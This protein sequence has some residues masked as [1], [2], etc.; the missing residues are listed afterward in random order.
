MPALTNFFILKMDEVTL[1][2]LNHRN[3]AVSLHST[4]NLS[5]FWLIILVLGPT[6]LL[7]RFTLTALISSTRQLFSVKNLVSKGTCLGNQRAAISSPAQISLCGVWTGSCWFALEQGSEPLK[8]A[9]LRYAA[10]LSLWHLSSKKLNIPK[11]VSLFFICL[12]TVNI[13]LPFV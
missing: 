12:I 7:F 5:L 8:F 11:K 4:Q 13:L 6:D 10:A 1:V 9:V 2:S 3:S